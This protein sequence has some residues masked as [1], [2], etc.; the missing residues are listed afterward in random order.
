MLIDVL[1]SALL[2]LLL[3]SQALL[4][5]AETSSFHVPAPTEA[6]SNSTWPCAKRW[7][8]CLADPACW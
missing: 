8:G 3:E 6:S 4:P 2:K 7:T 5:S 1:L